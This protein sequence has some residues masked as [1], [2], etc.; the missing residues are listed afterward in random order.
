MRI[1]KV[2]KK[3]ICILIISTLIIQEISWADPALLADNDIEINTQTLQVE[4]LFKNHQID[5]L[6]LP[7]LIERII[8]SNS[9]IPKDALTTV[10]VA[11]I[12]QLC[13]SWKEELDLDCNWIVSDDL[14]QIVIEVKTD[15]EILQVRYF[16]SHEKTQQELP[17][18]W[19]D[20]NVQRINR[21]LC[22]QIKKI[23]LSEKAPAQKHKTPFEIIKDKLDWTIIADDQGKE[24]IVTVDSPL[25]GKG[26][27][28]LLDKSSREEAGFLDV[29][30]IVEENG[31][32]RIT[33]GL[34]F[35]E[36]QY[37]G[38]HLFSEL[39]KALSNIIPENSELIINSVEQDDTLIQL[40][41]GLSWENTPLGKVFYD[42]GWHAYEIGV[43]DRETGE[44]FLLED[45]KQEW[46][47][48][49]DPLRFFKIL[50]EKLI[51]ENGKL[52]INGISIYTKMKKN[53]EQDPVFSKDKQHNSDY[54]D[55]L[56]R[57]EQE[58]GSGEV[59][60]NA[61]EPYKMAGGAIIGVVACI[62]FSPFLFSSGIR[63]KEAFYLYL[64][65]TTI[66][67]L[68]TTAV[69]ERAMFLPKRTTVL[70]LIK[71]FKTIAD[72]QDI[73]EYDNDAKGKIAYYSYV[74]KQL[75]IDTIVM[76][77]V[78]KMFQYIIYLHEMIHKKLKVKT[79]IVAVSLTYCLPSFFVFLVMGSV[80]F[81]SEFSKNDVILFF[82]FSIYNILVPFVAKL[83]SMKFGVIR[84][85]AG[86]YLL[87]RKNK[88]YLT[89]KE[90][91]DA[92]VNYVRKI[93]FDPLTGQQEY[94]RNWLKGNDQQPMV[95][96]IEC[97][98]QKEDLIVIRA[99]NISYGK[100]A[101]ELKEKLLL[102]KK[103]NISLIIATNGKNKERV[104]STFAAAKKV[105]RE[106]PKKKFITIDV[107][108][109]QYNLER[110]KELE[111]FFTKRLERI[112]HGTVNKEAVASEVH[113][114]TDRLEKMLKWLKQN[115]YKE[116]VLMGDYLAKKGNGYQAIDLLKNYK[117]SFY[118]PCLKMLVG[119]SEHF[120]LRVMLGD[121]EFSP[122]WPNM[123]VM[124]G[125]A[126]ID[127]LMQLQELPITQNMADTEKH[128]I[129][130]ARKFKEILIIELKKE[131]KPI[132][133]EN[134]RE[135]LK[136]HYRFHPKLISITEFIVEY[137]NFVFYENN[138]HTIYMIGA[139]PQ[140]FTWNGLKGIG[141]LIGIEEEFKKRASSRL[142]L[143]KFSR[144]IWA[145][146]NNTAETADKTKWLNLVEE[147]LS[148][149]VSEERQKAD[150][151]GK[152]LISEDVLDTLQEK[153]R[154]VIRSFS[155]GRG[156]V[157]VDKLEKIRIKL[158]EIIEDI[159]KP[160][161]KI[162]DIVFSGKASPFMKETAG[163]I[164]TQGNKPQERRKAREILGVN[165]VIT[166]TAFLHTGYQSLKQLM[167]V[168]SNGTVKMLDVDSLEGFH[169][170]EMAL[171][172]S[173][174]EAHEIE[175]GQSL[176]EI[177]LK[178]LAETQNILK[179][180]SYEGINLQRTKGIEVIKWMRTFVSLIEGLEKMFQG[181]FKNKKAEEEV[182][183]N[184]VRGKKLLDEN[185]PLGCIFL[186]HA[187]ISEHST[188]TQ[189]SYAIDTF[190]KCLSPLRSEDIRQTASESLSGML[191]V[192]LEDRKQA[193]RVFTSIMDNL[194]PWIEQ[195][196][197]SE[198]EL[199]Y[200]EQIMKP[201]VEAIKNNRKFKQFIISYGKKR[202][203]KQKQKFID[204]LM[205]IAQIKE[206]PFMTKK[207]QK[208]TFSPQQKKALFEGKTKKL[209]EELVQ[210][211]I[212]TA[213]NNRNRSYNAPNKKMV[214]AIDSEI[215]SN[216][217]VNELIMEN[218]IR[219]LRNISKNNEVLM[220]ILDEIEIIAGDVDCL[221]QS[222]NKK[223]SSGNS[224][225]NDVVIVTA[226][227]NI[228]KFSQAIQNGSYITALD[229]QGGQHE[230]IY[231]PILEVVLFA[232]L[233]ITSSKKEYL[234]ESYWRIDGVSDLNTNN[235]V[236]L[237]FGKEGPKK[238][239][240]LTIIPQIE[241][242]NIEDIANKYKNI[243][244]LIYSV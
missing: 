6:A 236:D 137:M 79:E 18:S 152:E 60:G 100:L 56:R 156:E 118:E 52:A 66:I 238:T 201:I 53:T 31:V 10:E 33:L 170:E 207:V 97:E 183:Y 244:L 213:N 49:L 217:N 25:K 222:V 226:Q 221:E 37:R 165:T 154:D 231:V 123:K 61:T 223:V 112:K 64:F 14:K 140:D 74:T 127:S 176:E 182:E 111:K 229:I 26:V 136:Q 188:S 40:S 208:D 179:A 175:K 96:L 93:T 35:I 44:T 225:L 191:S 47:D 150:T 88:R 174:K 28:A 181:W 132:T 169:A 50:K 241:K 215:S 146:I 224:N 196:G 119:R 227:R 172:L 114:Q 167:V 161:P 116:L 13:Q 242:Q 59:E 86:H 153:V 48:Y 185:D 228:T 173:A 92:I 109:T 108:S 21:Y 107:C 197:A 17:K 73:V 135:K 194:Y 168:D 205:E 30:D 129:L 138:N 124:E 232:L 71:P 151:T 139:I 19:K 134:I 94:W 210:M 78:P 239:V 214:I 120:F 27:L 240:V 200:K 143:L 75:Y 157:T 72:I 164:E 15:K 209:L 29:L 110:L 101:D 233:R 46:G 131:G 159:N 81:V 90:I 189:E 145:S 212:I 230:N 144:D 5:N 7:I 155:S 203:N 77:R 204:S 65:I 126:M 171:I 219:P 51:Y 91:D 41:E 11:E 4:S 106:I 42:S 234:M 3:S 58:N 142:R 16:F 23:S 84:S 87:S 95:Y 186:Q 115:K 166:P 133:Q 117:L 187:I 237:C 184:I 158:M 36:E 202:K 69:I 199:T 177:T 104:Y 24:F 206:R 180:Y 76:K 220:K 147:N 62:L 105:I 67:P 113:G 193:Q 43:Y 99:G 149:M 198:S 122:L 98:T 9:N 45:K 12:L 130:E 160:L 39:W 128:D 38:K 68:L 162:F 102:S 1:I 148:K 216:D 211:L 80:F 54:E 34:T 243:K 82:A 195:I 63:I 85:P 121:K 192:G 55:L 32:W 218:V 103:K 8:E 190:V 57:Y 125:P 178:K 235:L 70:P 89:R 163:G 2:I 83:I 22:K 20:V 141:A